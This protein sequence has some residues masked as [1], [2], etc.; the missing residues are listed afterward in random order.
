MVMDARWPGLFVPRPPLCQ[1]HFPH[2]APATISEFESQGLMEDDTGIFPLEFVAA[3]LGRRATIRNKINKICSC[4]EWSGSNS[5]IDVGACSSG[6]S[7]SHGAVSGPG[8]VL[9]DKNG[10]LV[11]LIDVDD[12]ETLLRQLQMADFPG[13]QS[14]I[15]YPFTCRHVGSIGERVAVQACPSLFGCAGRS[16][17]FM[18]ANHISYLDASCPRTFAC[19]RLVWSMCAGQELGQTTNL[20]Q[21]LSWR[22]NLPDAQMIPS[23]GERSWDAFE[24]LVLPLALQMPKFM[25]MVCPTWFG[26][27]T[28]PNCKSAAAFNIL[29]L[30]FR[31]LTL[32][33]ETHLLTGVFKLRVHP[34]S[35]PTFQALV[36]RSP[37]RRVCG[38]IHSLELWVKT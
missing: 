16:T 26:L 24:A 19:L 2:G 8:Q 4:M 27:P 5:E 17:P 35:Y 20:N 23:H 37:A 29:T 15:Q 30:L 25:S 18:V 10:Q 36:A 14:S 38:T 9:Y 7:Y 11:P 28:R 32:C 33:H 3:I 21:V 12:R 13:V 6:T 22:P 1:W 31:S 34:T